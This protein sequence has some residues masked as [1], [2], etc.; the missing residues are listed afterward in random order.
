MFD[1]IPRSR[2]RMSEPWLS[3]TCHRGGPA[4]DGGV[5]HD[6]PLE[7]PEPLGC[8]VEAGSAGPGHRGDRD[9][10]HEAVVRPRI[11]RRGHP[12]E[13]LIDVAVETRFHVQI[14]GR[15][16][17]ELLAEDFEAPGAAGAE[18]LE[19]ATVVVGEDVLVVDAFGAWESPRRPSE[20]SK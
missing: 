15:A 9:V 7:E 1:R 13:V 18:R 2:W 6:V 4:R 11:L 8:D 16:Q 5:S 10:D 20:P 12:D 17:S 19:L 14:G 3:L